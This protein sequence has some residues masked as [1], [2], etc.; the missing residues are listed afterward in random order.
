MEVNP[1]FLGK[2]IRTS[3]CRSLNEKQYLDISEHQ[4]WVLQPEGELV[5]L[6]QRQCLT[7]DQDAPSGL[8]YEIWGGKIIDNQMVVQVLN[9]SKEPQVVTL[10]LNMLAAITGKVSDG[11]SYSLRDLWKH[12]DLDVKLST[13]ND[14]KFNL[15]G[16]QS[17]LLTLKSSK[18]FT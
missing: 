13:E 15:S 16:H 8:S 14:V 7:V 3:K 5:N 17:V 11:I 4:S 12:A 10:S 6:Y 9:K 18:D 1:L 2:K